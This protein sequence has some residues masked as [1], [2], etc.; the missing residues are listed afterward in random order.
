[1]Y[2]NFT[3]VAPMFPDL[4]P[5][6]YTPDSTKNE[7]NIA[8]STHQSTHSSAHTL[9]TILQTP[10]HNDSEMAMIDLYPGWSRETVCLAQ[11]MCCLGLDKRWA[12]LFQLKNQPESF[13]LGSVKTDWH[14]I[15]RPVRIFFGGNAELQQFTANGYPLDSFLFSRI[16]LDMPNQQAQ[17]TFTDPNF[18]TFVVPLYILE[19]LVKAL[20]QPSE[21]QAIIDLTHDA[22]QPLIDWFVDAPLP[23]EQYAQYQRLATRVD[24]VR[25]NLIPYK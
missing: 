3:L 10:E 2:H 25:V 17:L 24:Y 9:Y 18:P 1:M 11:Y 8:S 20:K 19:Q 12:L 6:P 22:M 13:T 16:R 21:K 5:Q 15:D 23:R 4:P 7:W 14:A